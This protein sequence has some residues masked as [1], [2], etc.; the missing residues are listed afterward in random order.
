MG[1]W[2]LI[3]GPPQRVI[4]ASIHNQFETNMNNAEINQRRIDAS[5]RGVGV[6]CNFYADRAENA[7]IWDVEGKMYTDFAAGIAVLNTGHR[8]PAVV[9]AIAKQLDR[10]THTAYQI[11]PYESSVSSQSASTNWHPLPAPEKRPSS[12]RERK[13]LKTPSR[14]RARSQ[15]VPVSSH[16]LAHS[17]DAP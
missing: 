15:G 5:P 1:M 6:M 10:F 4:R 17:T 9:E 12:L 3:V 8:H 13:R 2:Y 14:L 7:T 11:V 16:S